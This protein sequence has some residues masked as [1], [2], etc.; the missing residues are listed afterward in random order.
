MQ[1]QC[2]IRIAIRPVFSAHPRAKQYCSIELYISGDP[3]KE[4]AYRTLG[5]WIQEF[6]AAIL[7]I[8]R[9]AG[10]LGQIGGP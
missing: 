8:R 6:H 3:R 7:D 2:E 4:I 10:N 9:D 1:D 5:I